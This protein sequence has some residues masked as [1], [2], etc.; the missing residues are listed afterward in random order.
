MKSFWKEYGNRIILFLVIVAVIAIFFLVRHIIKVVNLPADTKLKPE[1][2]KDDMLSIDEWDYAALLAQVIEV[3]DA[4]YWLDSSPRC[5]TYEKLAK[6]ED[7]QLIT[8]ANAYKK[9]KNKTLRNA[10]GETWVN[11]CSVFYTDWEK[12]LLDRM[13]TLGIQ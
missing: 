2:D 7:N 5:D 6:L 13:T 10:M 12:I 1:L 9:S 11:G 8:I 3:L 4:S